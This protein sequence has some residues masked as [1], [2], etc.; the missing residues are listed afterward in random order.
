MKR[1]FLI[2]STLAGLSLI[3]T[4]ASAEPGILYIPTDAVTLRP[5]NM[6]PC[7]ADVNSALGCGGASMEVEEP[8]YADAEALTTALQTN[9]AEYDLLVTNTRPPEYISYTML[10]ASDEPLDMAASGYQSFTCAFGGINCAARGRNDIVSTSG[11]TGNCIDPEIVHAATFAVGRN[12]GLEGIDNPEDWMH[13]V[14][15]DG[16]AGGPDYMTPPL[17]FQDV[18]NDRVQ[19][20]GF[21]DR[22]TQIDLPL[23]CAGIDHVE[24]DGP[25]GMQGQNSHQDLLEYLGP[26]VEDLDP[27]E[28]NNVVPAEGT[29]LMEGEELVLDVEIVDADPIV[30]ARWTVSSSALEEAGVP[31]GMLT[32][33]TNDACDQ[34]WEEV[35]LKPTDSDWSVSLGGLPAGEYTITLEAADYHGNVAEMVTVMVTIE[36]D[37]DSGTTSGGSEGGGNVDDTGGGNVTNG[38]GGFESTGGDD[39]SGDDTG[40]GQDDSGDGSGCSCRTTPAPGGAMLMLLGLMGLGTLRRR[41]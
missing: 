27:P 28:L 13:Y 12:L 6:A 5:L 21:N 1:T 2:S 4:V 22:G 14:N 20:Q 40:S 7:G 18:C 17:G 23:E 11:T 26:V 41:W 30:G 29:V 10:L 8:P 36:G 24:C 32:Q 37:D 31:G 19:Q 34:G 38:G 3:P 39:D 25:G 33:C 15:D 35:S 16:P 9:F